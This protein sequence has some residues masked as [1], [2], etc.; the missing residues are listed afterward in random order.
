MQLVFLFTVFFCVGGFFRATT[1]VACG[2][3]QARGRVGTVTAG[4]CHSHIATECAVPH[5]TPVL[6]P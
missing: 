6:D 3:S 1:P 5:L 2:S 4:L